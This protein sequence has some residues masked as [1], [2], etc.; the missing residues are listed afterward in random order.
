MATRADILPIISLGQSFN[1]NA[2]A[3]VGASA[4]ND[5]T[6]N[7]L[8]D[9][10][11]IG[12]QN[13]EN[14]QSLLET[15]AGMFAFDKERFRR[16]RDQLR[17]QNKESLSTP[18][19]G[20]QL[21][22]VQEMTG[23]FGVKA[24]AGVAALAFFAKEL[25]ANTDILKLPQQL[26]SIRAM[27]NFVKGVG[28]IG[29]LG[30]GGKLADDAKAAI[31]AV[32]VDPS[33]ITKAV[34]TMFDD[35]FKGIANLL[36]GTP[37]NPSVFTRIT[38]SFTKSLD[39]VKDTFTGIKATIT[40]STAFKS[41]TTFADDIA[42]SISKTFKPFKDAIMS[43]F[44]PAAAGAGAA[45]ASS[46]VLA[47]IITPLKGIASAIGKI[48]LPLTIILGV[49][50]G[51]KG[52][53]EEYKDEQ[54]I[55]DGLRGGIKGIVDG[56]IG[57]FV[58]I[59]G[60]AFDFVLSF[61][62]LDDTG[63]SV[64]TFAKDV[65]KAFEESVGGLVDVFTGI[66]S[67]DPKRV[68]E[69]LVNL[70][71]GTLDWASDILFAPINLAINFVKDIFGIG[72]E[73]AP[74]FNL[75]D[76]IFGPEGVMTQLIDKIKDIFTID[77]DAIKQDFFDFGRFIKAVTLASGVAVATAANIFSDETAGEA[78]KRKFDEVMSGGGDTINEG[79]TYETKNIEG[80]KTE[81]SKKTE[82]L[83]E[84][85]TNKGGDI[86]I[87][88]ID[89]SVKDQSQKGYKSENSY[90]PLSTANDPYFD[91]INYNGFYG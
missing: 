41:M 45:G 65:T 26:K 39:T 62:G 37:D 55:L 77:F 10:R 84:G 53:E 51:Y 74:A 66:L 67:F 58:R 15:M 12:R 5:N 4:A 76:Y 50:D 27:T 34:K 81:T 91:R 80:D 82:M 33:D 71:G 68:K 49:F 32:K 42:Q 30:L 29:S 2:L 79:D 75:K 56:F 1:A 22:G 48:F 6:V 63:E 73:D 8:E 3:G 23:G 7:L 90:A 36:K 31:K 86:V 61:F 43:I 35:T 46:G 11:D 87:G 52:F 54:S 57:S 69:G 16:E 38:N 83:K 20:I 18:G 13:E 21:P 59:I 64:S 25:G 78:Y 72:E 40:E 9:L 60:S 44:K 17:E 28:N 24:L 47:S 89:Q 70:V 19:A 88:S 14:T 85:D